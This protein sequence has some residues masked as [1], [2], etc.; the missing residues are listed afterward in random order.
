MKV[1]GITEY[2]ANME[3]LNDIFVGLDTEFRAE[4]LPKRYSVTIYYHR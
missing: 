4:V 1:S 2:T 3:I